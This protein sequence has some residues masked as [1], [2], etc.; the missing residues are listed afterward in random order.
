[1]KF[2]YQSAV[3]THFLQLLIKV[4][5]FYFY[6]DTILNKGIDSYFVILQ[7]F[8][9][10]HRLVNVEMTGAIVPVSMSERFLVWLGDSAILP[11][12]L[13]QHSDGLQT[14]DMVFFI[15]KSFNSTQLYHSKNYCANGW[16]NLQHITVTFRVWS[17]TF[18]L[19][20]SSESARRKSKESIFCGILTFVFLV[21]RAAAVD[22][23]SHSL[24]FW[25]NV[26]NYII[27]Q[28]RLWFISNS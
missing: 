24:S 4:V 2:I 22:N 27:N 13:L 10:S 19:L 14:V 21:R 3:I 9:N 5:L 18:I 15:K 16:V 25:N 12:S 26:L 20:P 17:C 23:G 7:A 11:S 8:R 28:R 1:M 6:F